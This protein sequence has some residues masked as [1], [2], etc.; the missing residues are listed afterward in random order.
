MM[1]SDHI[2]RG[3]LNSRHRMVA[4][5]GAE[6]WLVIPPPGRGECVSGNFMV[7]IQVCRV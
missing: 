6:E 3:E 1:N 5:F 7:G 4:L 2:G